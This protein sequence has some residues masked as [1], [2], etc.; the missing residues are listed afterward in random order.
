MNAP[1]EEAELVDRALHGDRT[2]FDRLVQPYRRELHVHCYRMLASLHDAEDLVQESLLRAWR[3]LRS[4]RGEGPL[5]SWLYKIAT[6]TCLNHLKR[7]PRVVVPADA[8]PGYAPP[9]AFE[10]FWLEPYPDASLDPADSAVGKAETS[11]AFLCA[12][13]VLPPLQRAALILREVLG[14]TAKETADLLETT[15]ASVNSALQRARSRLDPSLRAEPP[16]AARPPAPEEELLVRR[17]IRAWEAADIPAL[18]GLL[19]EDATLAMP[20]APVWFRGPAAIGEFLSTVPAEGRLDLIPLT[21][22]RANGRPAVAAYMPGE[23][24]GS[25]QAYGIMVL[26]VKAGAIEAITG[27]ADPDLFRLFVLPTHLEARSK[28]ARYVQRS[29]A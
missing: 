14:F 3:G 18:V 13:Q 23:A 10:V 12:V 29:D 19:A 22:V 2:A 28:P 4:F 15:P 5:R 16:F 20:P 8:A 25:P 7:R 9:P 6:N 11:L 17:F 27:F 24:T 1:G 21:R 26:T